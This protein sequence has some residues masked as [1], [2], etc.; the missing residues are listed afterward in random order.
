MK[1]YTTNNENPSLPPQWN[2]CTTCGSGITRKTDPSQQCRNC[3][4]DQVR[5]ELSGSFVQYEQL[6]RES[7]SRIDNIG[8]GK[9]N[10][11]GDWGYGDADCSSTGGWG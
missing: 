5:R 8:F 2:D 7:F 10:S 1:D 9:H 3:Y 11:P 4:E 6:D